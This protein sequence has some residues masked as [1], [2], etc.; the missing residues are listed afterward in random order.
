MIENGRQVSIEYTLKLD[1]GSTAD[2]NLGQ[3]P[4]VYE[5]GAQ[6]LLP[7]FEREVA[8]M[9]VDETRQFVLSPEDGYGTPNP[10][11]RQEIQADLV[12]EDARREGVQLVS[13]DRSGNRRIVRVDEV[14]GDRIVLDFN[15]PLAGENL[16]F[17][18]RVVRI[19]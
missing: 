19:D 2:T 5:Q 4:L 7:A 18:V 8:G 9:E 3:D 16:H 14:R 6:Q 10:E 17:E 15:H 13:E 12:P 1:D 11:L